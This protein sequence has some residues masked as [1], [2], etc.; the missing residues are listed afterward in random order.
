MTM[1]SLSN[2]TIT[3]LRSKYF[4]DFDEDKKYYRILFRPSTSVQARELTQLQT[5]L[6]LQVTRFA[7]HVFK[8]GSVV[9]GCVITPLANCDFIR[10]ADAFGNSTV[11]YI[12]AVSDLKNTY[13][14]TNNTN[15]TYATRA[16]IYTAVTGYENN[17][18]DT[19]VIYVRYAYTGKDLSGN[20]VKTFS[21]GDTLYVYNA[22]QSVSAALDPTNKIGDIAVLTP[23]TVA[24][25]AATAAGQGYLVQVSD[26]Q[27][28][29]KGFMQLVDTQVVVV[30]KYLSDANNAAVGFDTKEEII[31][32][33]QDSSLNDNSNG[34][35][36]YNAPGAHRL[37]L[38]PTLV[39]KSK[40]DTTYKNF[41]PVLE[42]DQNTPVISRVDP[43]YAS[44]G[45][46]IAQEKYEESGDYTVFPHAIETAPHYSNSS[47][48]LYKMS[49]GISYVKGHRVETIGTRVLNA[50]RATTTDIDATKVISANYGNYVYCKEVLGA[51]N[52][53]KLG[54]VALYDTAQA[55][56]SDREGISGALSGN[57]VGYANIKSVLPYSGVKGTANA[58][59]YVY[60][61]NIRMNVNK[62]FK[63]DVKSMYSA[64]T[65]GYTKFKADLVLEASKAV[66]YDS[67]YTPLVFDV[68]YNAVKTLSP[69]NSSRITNYYVRK[70]V[71]APLANNSMTFSVGTGAAGGTEQLSSTKINDYVVVLSANAFSSNSTG[72]V[73]LYS[74]V[75]STASNSTATYV[76]GSSTT[77]DSSYKVGEMIRVSSGTDSTPHIYTIGGILSPTLMY[78]TPAATVNSVANTFQKYFPDGTV[79]G[80]T[81]D[82]ALSINQAANTFTI[83]H[84]IIFDAGVANT[85]YVQ[86]PVSRTLAVHASK[87][88]NSNR[89]VKID[90]S[91]NGIAN[92][93][94]IAGPWSLGIPDVTKINNIWVGTSY[95]NTSTN[96]SDW[97]NF[98][99]GQRDDSY[100]V[101]TISI[102]PAYATNITSSTKILVDLNHLV[103]DR[104]GGAGFYT[105]ESYPIVADGITAN[106]TKIAIADIPLF[107]S[108]AAGRVYDLRNCI[109]FRPTKALTANSV[110]NTDPANTLITIN[111]GYAN[112]N[113]WAISADG[114]YHAEADSNFTAAYE[115]YL[116]RR[117]LVLLGPT[118]ALTYSSSV[119]EIN[120]KTPIN[121]SDATIIAEAVVPPF[122]SLTMREAETSGRRDLATQITLTSNRRYTMRDIG[123]LE[124]RINRL[125]YYTVLT[126]LEKAAKDMNIP[127]ATTQLDRF[128]NGIFAEPFNS[129]NLGDTNNAE[130]RHAIDPAY[131]ISRPPFKEHQIDFRYNSAES[132][133]VVQK[134]SYLLLPYTHEQFAQNKYATGYRGCTELYWTWNG[135]VSLSPDTVIWS[136]STPLA[137]INTTVDLLSPLQNLMAAGVLNA[138]VYGKSSTVPTT[139]VK[140]TVT[141]GG[142]G[143]TTKTDTTTT[144]TTTTEVMKLALGSDAGEAKTLLNA[145]VD[146]HEID[147]IKPIDVAF[148]AKSLRPGTTLHCFMDDVNMDSY[149]APGKLATSNSSGLP[150]EKKDFTYDQPAKNIVT[151]TGAKGT[152]LVANSSGGVAGIVSIPANTFRTGERQFVIC[153]V[154]NLTTGSSAILTKAVGTFHA[155]GLALTKQAATL[156][157]INPKVFPTVGPNLVTTV[158]TTSTSS[159]FVADPPDTGSSTGDG[160]GA[161]GGDPI[162]QSFVL[163]A[164]GDSSGHFVTKI[165]LY[166]KK[167][168]NEHGITVYMAE[169]NNGQPD[170]SKLL[171]EAVLHSSEVNVSDDAQIA[172][173]FEFEHPIYMKSG[174]GYAVIIEPDAHSADYLIW[175]SV[176]GGADGKGGFNIGPGG[177]QGEQV[178]KQ[179][180]DGV[181]FVSSNRQSWTQYQKNDLKFTLYRARFT[182]TSGTAVFENEDDD[183]LTI[184]GISRNGTTRD[185]IK[186]G[187]YVYR[188]D[189]GVYANSSTS[190]PFGK[191]Q[192]INSTSGSLI[193][194]ST[195]DRGTGT[196]YG[197]FSNSVGSE[198]I[199][200]HR[201]NFS[202]VGVP[203]LSY[204]GAANTLIA[205]ANIVSVDDN[206]YHATIPKLATMTPQYTGLNF[207]V[208][209]LDTSYNFD[210]NWMS[211]SNEDVNEFT[212]K[213]RIVM[214]RSNEAVNLG[215]GVK[216]AKIQATLKTNDTLVSPVIDLTRKGSY[217]VENIVN[218]DLTNEHTTHGN[219]LAKYISK[220]V[221]LADGQDAEDLKVILTAFRP[222]NAN[223]SIYAKLQAADDTEPFDS[224]MWTLLPYSNDG[225]VVF[226]NQN[227]VT[228]YK[229][230]E[231]NISTITPTVQ[232]FNGNTSVNSA[233]DYISFTNN[234]F[235]NNQIVIYYTAAGNTG[236]NIN[237]L[238]GSSSNNTSYYVVSSNSTALKLALTQGGTALG[239]NSCSVSEVGH[240]LK[241]AIPT[242]LNTAYLNPDSTPT[243]SVVEYYN[244]SGSRMQTFK[245]FAIKAVMTSEDR[246]NIPRMNDLRAIALQ[247]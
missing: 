168:S 121:N 112:A 15:S 63:D 22:N 228:D 13:L 111:P 154:D 124:N 119:P 127:S 151:V 37:K 47:L 101:A 44:L 86:Y 224:K 45:D 116:G 104:S 242:V 222:I 58:Q 247:K 203:S 28:Y 130:Y 24:N 32:E 234:V 166:F 9:T 171:G 185:P 198:R 5:I 34:S 180:Y 245:Y 177:V 72:T 91:N 57:I 239:I 158:V 231:F 150:I 191:V 93:V 205:S 233:G 226:S 59:Y 238:S 79:L 165:D 71:S 202:A 76:T 220:K 181:L 189:D 54:E 142:G 159:K 162:A 90:C 174:V 146:V 218:N 7:D 50:L 126:T 175:E 122:P 16:I 137:A 172:T 60:I 31:T 148:Y 114:Q 214:S 246:V 212:D 109:D 12:T 178:S 241:G 193:L 102:K 211:V 209:G 143:T 199:Q 216:S 221:V 65:G 187:D 62:S 89:L 147:Y 96:R 120:P 33:Y 6:Q 42:F 95:A 85:A 152:A 138:Q 219:A 4:D 235:V 153:D 144:N 123:V 52:F 213:E 157:T 17:Y 70:T 161:S 82:S 135:S 194:D 20:D 36:N 197:S 61:F 207:A 27:V 25:A 39:V 176:V 195:I 134:G 182:S 92:S 51:M 46:R 232:P 244:S 128:K 19:N 217:Y 156:T 204:S 83:T 141:T 88:L 223:V 170:F 227:D 173:T 49:T 155:S 2:A 139:S 164:P 237:G 100:D 38:T 105:V 183:Y 97:F 186:V 129:H 103:A 55:A 136:D 67:T 99:N 77:F 140:T 125:E 56:I 74:T 48:F 3:T 11:D 240:Y 179:P 117:D 115:Y 110:A 73:S 230:Y 149:V 167:K 68:G 53:D 188:T 87:T 118:G 78:V 131:S 35:S 94:N 80:L 106:S 108:K 64:G 10:V 1:A 21:T 208:K 26:G 243:A 184:T 18:P 75:N 160:G 81:S 30:N 43:Q 145:V 23:N 200:I 206:K 14:L 107:K 163:S 196:V 66:I 190:A 113:T 8:D 210:S 98:D 41:F 69:N 132:A 40:D 229:E 225:D 133:S 29:Q 84:G 201:P 169:M 192:S 236:I 215:A